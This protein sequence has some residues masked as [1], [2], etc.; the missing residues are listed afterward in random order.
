[1]VAKGFR[2]GKD[3]WGNSTT[4]G[5][6]YGAA[7]AIY[8][9]DLAELGGKGIRVTIVEMGYMTNSEEDMQMQDPQFQ[10]KMTDGIADGIDAFMADRT[11]KEH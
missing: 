11:P 2:E 9:Q 6:A 4:K 3:Q 8:V 10:K 7:G 1:M 5:T